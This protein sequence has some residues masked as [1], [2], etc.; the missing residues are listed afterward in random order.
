[1]LWRESA[2][3]SATLARYQER[4][5]SAGAAAAGAMRHQGGR[6]GR[7]CQVAGLGG[8]RWGEGQ[9]DFAL[10]ALE[11]GEI[12]GNQDVSQAGTLGGEQGVVPEGT[13]LAET[14]FQ[15]SHSTGGRQPIVVAGGQGCADR[16]QGPGGGRAACRF[17]RTQGDL[18]HDDA[19]Q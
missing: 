19:A 3:N 5:S 12:I 1:M 11:I 6:S 4:G 9:W 16:M 8:E 7:R 18:R 10:E 13:R 14:R 2:Q 17:S 15:S